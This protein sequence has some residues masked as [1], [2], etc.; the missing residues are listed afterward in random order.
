[1]VLVYQ[2]EQELILTYAKSNPAYMYAAVYSSTVT[3]FKSTDFGANWI[4]LTTPTDFQNQCSQ[5]WYDLYVRVNPKNPDKVYVG[6]VDVYRSTNGTNFTNI[7]NGYAGGNVHV[8]QHY[9]F[10]HPTQENTFI[11]CNDGGIWYSANNG[12]TFINL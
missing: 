4:N 9:L 7:T 6:M 8:D 12:D 5:A 11:I 10:F 3:I 2:Q 1:M